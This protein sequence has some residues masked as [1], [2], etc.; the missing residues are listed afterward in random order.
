MIQH[1]WGGG[2]SLEQLS[3]LLLLSI[4][5]GLDAFSVSLGIG[6]QAVRMKYVLLTGLTI[7]LFH[8]FMPGLGMLLGQWLSAGASEWAELAGGFMLFGLGAY[9]VFASFTEKHAGLL[10]PQRDWILAFRLKC[11]YRQLSCR[12]QSRSSGSGC[13][14]NDCL[15]WAVQYAVDVDRFSY[16]TKGRSCDGDLQRASRRQYSMCS[17]SL[18]YLLTIVSGRESSM[19]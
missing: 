9:T 12:L 14:D 18:F 16:W 7:G 13:D 17:W 15:F 4:A 6:M 1:V 8:I 2:F 19:I 11:E 10:P 5:L 3:S